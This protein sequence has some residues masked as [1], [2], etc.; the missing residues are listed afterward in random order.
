MRVHREKEP[1]GSFRA[2]GYA[3]TDPLT[4]RPR[5]FRETAKTLAAQKS[6]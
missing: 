4:H 6:R 2:V 3:G 5:Y 1:S